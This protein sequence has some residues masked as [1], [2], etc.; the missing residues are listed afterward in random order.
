M[1]KAKKKLIIPHIPDWDEFYLK[2][3]ENYAKRAQ[4][5]RRQFAAL[6]VDNKHKLVSSGYNGAPRSVKSS[7]EKGYCYRMEKNIPQ[8]ANY[9]L[10]RSVHAEMNAIMRVGL[11]ACAGATMYLYSWD[12]QEERVCGEL[13]YG[14]PPCLM[15]AKFIVQAGIKEVVMRLPGNRIRRITLRELTRKLDR[16][17]FRYP[18]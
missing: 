15:C 4:C 3:A 13:P 7:V 9:E 18:Y 10:C 8:G 6:I 2:L 12:V 5:L 11:D 16:D 17:D 14:N 1:A